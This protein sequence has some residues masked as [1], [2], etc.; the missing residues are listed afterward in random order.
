MVAWVAAEYN[1]YYTDDFRT[2]GA[3]SRDGGRTWTAFTGLN[4]Q[5]FGGEVA[6]SATDPQRLI[7]LPTHFASPDQYVDDPLGLYVS[8]DGGASWRHEDPPGGSDALHR[9]LWWFTRRALAADRVDGRFYLMSDDGHF[10]ES[11]D[12]ALTWQEAANSPPCEAASGCHVFGQ[13]QAEPGT[14][15]R[16]WASTGSQ[17]MYVSNDAGATKWEHL[18]T[19]DEARAFGFGAPMPGSSRLTVFVYGRANGDAHLG[20]YRSTDAGATWLLISDRPNGLYQTVMTVSGD[21]AAAGRV[22]VGFQG[23]GFAYGVDPTVDN[24]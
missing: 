10:F 17:G 7:W 1:R 6:V 4:K 22:Y 3:I 23:N 21:P 16:L 9:Y 5:M 14:A 20:L 24:G 11:T 19:V 18:A 13:I 12:G 8:T 2:R 15:G